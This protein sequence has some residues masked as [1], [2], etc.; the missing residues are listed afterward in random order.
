MASQQTDKEQYICL[1]CYAVGSLT[2]QLRCAS[3]DSDVV[4]SCEAVQRMTPRSEA[5]HFKTPTVASSRQWF[6]LTCNGFE[7]VVSYTKAHTLEEAINYA[8][9]AM[10]EWYISSKLCPTLDEL[11]LIQSKL[12]NHKEYLQWCEEKWPLVAVSVEESKV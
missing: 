11:G 3:C 8:K 10:C 6:L 5:K 9:S 4:A 12:L 7:T 1:N 2:E